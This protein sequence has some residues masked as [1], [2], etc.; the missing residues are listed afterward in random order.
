MIACTEIMF[1]FFYTPETLPPMYNRWIMR[2]ANNKDLVTALHAKYHGKVIYGVKSDILRDYCLK[3]NIDPSLA[4]C[5]TR[6]P[7]P[8][9]VL[10]PEDGNCTTK[11]I[12]RRWL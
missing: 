4:D 12:I 9:W 11:H 2:M 8:Q 7:I 5:M 1:S 3:R 6:I 10:H